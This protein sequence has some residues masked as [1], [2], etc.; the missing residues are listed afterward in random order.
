MELTLI[1]VVLALLSVVVVFG[2]I[3]AGGD[4]ASRQMI[5]W[6]GQREGTP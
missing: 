3:A 5:A 6:I 4:N 2:V 1:I